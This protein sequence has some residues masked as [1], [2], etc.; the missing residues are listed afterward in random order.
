[1]SEARVPADWA[2]FFINGCR[3]GRLSPQR[4]AWSLPLLPGARLREGELHWVCE[5]ALLSET[6]QAT[7]LALREQG[8]LS[9]WRGEAFACEAPVDDP[10]MTRGAELFRMERAAFRF[11]GLMSR[12]VHINGWL[13]DGRLLCGR[14]A[15]SKPTDPGLLDNLAAGGL[16]AGEDPLACARRELWEEAG[17][18]AAL[19]AGLRPGGMLRTVRPTAQGLHDEV[20]HV[21]NLDLPADF[22]PANQDGEV[23]EFLVWPAS[24]AGLQGF[25]PDAAAVI[26]HALRHGEGHGDGHG[27]GVHGEDVHG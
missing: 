4:A 8:V 3:L 12:A 26:A 27:Q 21:F 17:V 9:G 2:G 24:A 7:A 16:T 14:R 20:L 10:C 11:F 5:A 15:L 23:A 22:R 25:T 18:D 1:M 19:S 13:P 6:M